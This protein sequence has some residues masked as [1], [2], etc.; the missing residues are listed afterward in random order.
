MDRIYMNFVNA[1]L[2][3]LKVVLGLT[4]RNRCKLQLDQGWLPVVD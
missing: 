1:S 2:V 4:V 3:T